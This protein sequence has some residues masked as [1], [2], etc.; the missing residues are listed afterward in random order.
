M[1]RMAVTL[2][3][4][5]VVGCSSGS[6]V[7]LS[8]SSSDLSHSSSDVYVVPER[9]IQ[10]DA[11]VADGAVSKIDVGND[12][13]AD[14]E[15]GLRLTPLGPGAGGYISTIKVHPTDRR[16]IYIATDNGGVA[17][18]RDG[19]RTWPLIMNG[20]YNTR[21]ADICFDPKN[22]KTLFAA[23]GGGVFKTTDGGDSWSWKRSGFP[24]PSQNFDE[25]QWDDLV[26]VAVHP[27]DG[28]IVFAGSGGSMK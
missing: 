7:G 6:L 11:A 26:S 2:M 9:V 17:R 22:A 16:V 27:R 25:R 15:A 12:V 19:G 14:V 20:L 21:V 13:I 1:Q 8:D 18:S 4:A 23:T 5:T 28:N 10:V 24:E 3:I